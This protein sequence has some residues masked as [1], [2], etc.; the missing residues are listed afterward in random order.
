MGGGGVVAHVIIVSPQSQLDS[1]LGFGL[2]GLDLGLG[3]DN[4][5]LGLT[6]KSHKPTPTT[7]PPLTFSYEGEL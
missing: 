7:P 5:D 1:G 2:R 4:L 6:L 3:L